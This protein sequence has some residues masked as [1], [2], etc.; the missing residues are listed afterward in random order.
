MLELPGLAAVAGWVRLPS[1]CERRWVE[2]GGLSLEVRRLRSQ[3][4]SDVW[5]DF[6]QDPDAADG[7]VR[8]GVADGRRQGGISAIQVQHEMELGSI[9]TAWMVLHRYRSV[10]V[11][12]G[13]ERLRGDVEVDE[14]FIGGPEPGVRGRGA[15]GKVLI[16][17]AVER[18][19]GH[20][21]R[22]RLSVID[23]ASA[24]S[25]AAFL[26]ANVEPGSHVITDGW[27]AYP[28][29]TRDRYEHTGTSVSTSGLPAHEV[30]P[31]VHRT[32][33][34]VKRWLLGTMQGSVSPEHMQ[35]YLDE[36][37]FRFNR[38][39]A[40]SRGLLFHTLLQ[41]AVEGQPMTYNSMRKTGRTRPRPR[42][43]QGV[44]GTPRSLDVGRPEL[45]WRNQESP[46]REPK[47][48]VP[49]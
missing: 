9:Q 49:T 16:A 47:S 33:S 19:H 21:G 23:D 20:F 24:V 10:M 14:S 6:R 17:G 5:H 44:R 35:A 22:V 28:S 48:R 31:G 15:L 46:P 18:D 3:D 12:P 27:S 4:I 34:L 42:P 11:R 40:R 30:L 8:G 2:V 45:P 26:D 39:N 32:F 13:R 43:I 25:L 1:V 7:V 37:V 41:Q 36:W 29:A 38:H